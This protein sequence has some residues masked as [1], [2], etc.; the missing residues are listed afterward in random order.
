VQ[1]AVVAGAALEQR[2]TFADGVALEGTVRSADDGRPIAGAEISIAPDGPPVAIT[3]A[4]GSFHLAGLNF[5][6]GAWDVRAAAPGFAPASRRVDARAATVELE[7]D[8]GWRLVGRVLDDEGRGL[9]DARVTA[10]AKRDT[11]TAFAW[12]LREARSGPDGAFELTCLSAELDYAVLVRA[13]GRGAELRA[14]PR[15]ERRTTQTLEPVVLAPGLEVSGVVRRAD[16]SAI[17]GAEILVAPVDPTDVG[18]QSQH[19][20]TKTF[21]IARAGAAD[22]WLDAPPDLHALGA[23]RTRAR[24]DGSYRCVDLAPGTYRVSALTDAARLVAR[25]E[26]VL[27]NA[28]ASGID[29]VLTGGGTI[30]GR[31]LDPE[32]RPLAGAWVLLFREGE[33]LEKRSAAVDGEGRFRFEGLDPERYS[34][35]ASYATSTSGGRSERPFARTDVHD[36]VPGGPDVEV[37][38]ARNVRLGGTVVDRDER[39][40]AGALVNA[41]D[42]AGEWY[43]ARCDGAGAFALDVPDGSVLALEGS[44]ASV[45]GA[46]PSTGRL[47]GVS[48]PGADVVLRLR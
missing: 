15:G 34:V 24:A 17:A 23:R 28:S 20:T 12:D 31:V 48:V 42:S 32:R 21:V 3:G 2:L 22:T 7:L 16:G 10:T 30:S 8:T 4:D 40:L 41:Q 39:P 29:L 38:L 26:V 37:V 43:Q 35:S 25:R 14:A 47:E 27:T 6:R 5:E 19:P 46:P 13:Q 18:A 36:L 9:A 45:N 33:H 1:V 44:W 11:G